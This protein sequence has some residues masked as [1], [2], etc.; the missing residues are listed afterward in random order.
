MSTTYVT[1]TLPDTFLSIA[2]GDRVIVTRSGE[3]LNSSSNFEALR[4]Q[5]SNQAFIQGTVGSSA[6][7]GINGGFGGGYSVNIAGTGTVFS[8][9]S[10]GIAWGAVRLYGIGEGAQPNFLANAGMIMSAGGAGVESGA[11]GSRLINTGV[12]TA[13]TDAIHVF[14]SFTAISN[15][16]DLQGASSALRIFNAAGITLSNDGTM[17]GALY[18]IEASLGSGHRFTN[19]GSITSGTA[20]ALTT[21]ADARISNTGTIH[22]S[23]FA[24]NLTGTSNTTI[25]NAGVISGTLLLGGGDVRITNTGAINGPI[26]I[27]FDAIGPL[28][29]QNAGSIAASDSAILLGGGADRLVNTGTI[30]GAIALRHGDDLYDGREGVWAAADAL[31]FGGLYGDVGNDTLLGGRAAETMT[32][33]VGF[34]LLEGGGGGDALFGGDDADTLLGG[35][36]NDTVLGGAGADDLDGGAGLDLLDYR[37]SAAVNVNLTVGLG[38][39][40]EA[41]GDVILGFEMLA[42]GGANDT[43]TGA[44]GTET[45]IGRDGSDVLTGLNG[46]DRLV[47]Q[48]GADTLEGGAGADLL[49]GGEGSDVFLYGAITE[50]TASLAGRDRIADFQLGAPGAPLD[51]INLAA[52]D[53]I[54]GGAD[55]AFSFIATAAFTAAGQL[56]YF[57]QGGVRTLVEVETTGDNRAD[58]AI[59]LN[60][61]LALTASDFVL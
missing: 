58:F 46:N 31:G 40:G 36:G 29:L 35:E 34:D 56:R 16:G 30:Q 49:L 55:N 41:E 5:G 9:E 38:L 52:I 61:A 25:A 13:R 4:L 10:N 19:A 21:T 17:S 6:G 42:G 39:G 51:R 48:A 57:T 53:A 37:T 54:P 8:G 15:S 22:G 47:G 60:G 18:G 43:L 45:L 7:A 44:A 28:V 32:G 2:V 3:V 11:A 24:F 50:S 20:I 14:A 27:N 12:I 23:T 59:L 1:T 26:Q 33:D